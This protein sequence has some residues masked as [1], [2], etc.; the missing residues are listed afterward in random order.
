MIEKN[1]SGFYCFE[2]VHR[3]K[4]VIDMDFF[5]WSNLRSIQTYT[6]VDARSSFF[7][8]YSRSS[9]M[10]EIIVYYFSSQGTL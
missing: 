4:L 9:F 1:V 10:K 6:K 7:F 5:S 3:Y 2:F 8:F